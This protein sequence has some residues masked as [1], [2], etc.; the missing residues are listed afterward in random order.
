MP[1]SVRELMHEEIRRSVAK[2][3]KTTAD[4][5]RKGVALTPCDTQLSRAQCRLELVCNDFGR[6]ARHTNLVIAR[7]QTPVSLRPSATTPRATH[8]APRAKPKPRAR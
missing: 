8:C 3:R 6:E 2:G 5:C 1:A 7:R 4:G